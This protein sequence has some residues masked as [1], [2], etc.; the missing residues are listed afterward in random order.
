MNEL[1]ARVDRLVWRGPRLFQ[2][3]STRR[4]DRRL[5]RGAQGR[6]PRLSPREGG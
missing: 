6:T 4:H 3:G 2:T 5:R 1:D